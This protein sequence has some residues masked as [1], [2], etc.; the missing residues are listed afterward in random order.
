MPDLFCRSLPVIAGFV[1]HSLN[2]LLS[3][4][5][6]IGI[7]AG[8][9]FVAVG[10]VVAQVGGGPTIELFAAWWLALS[11][12]LL[13]FL[14]IKIAWM[15][16]IGTKSAICWSIAS[17]ALLGGMLLAGMYGMRHIYSVPGLD[18][19]IMRALHGTA[20]VIGFSIFGILGWWL[21]WS[22]PQL[23]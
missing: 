12:M 23:G 2:S 20:N 15:P 17:A 4:M 10:I 16:S 7:A 14:Q 8:V 6:V 22:E 3:K 13:A 1:N 9:P 18:I 11:A 21:N 5:K 19:P